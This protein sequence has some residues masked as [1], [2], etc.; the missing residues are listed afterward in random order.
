MA[1]ATEKATAK[2]ELEAAE[3]TS[4]PESVK[5]AKSQKEIEVVFKKLSIGVNG[6][7]RVG[8]KV[9]LTAK[10]AKDRESRGEVEIL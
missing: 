9:M 8:E 10:E 6:I 5:R 4:A 3:K 7:R 1:K 2:P